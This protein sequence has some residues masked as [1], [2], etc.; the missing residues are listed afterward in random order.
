MERDCANYVPLEQLRME[1]SIARRTG[2]ETKLVELW[3]RLHYEF[4]SA[5]LNTLLSLESQ[6]NGL[7]L[8]TDTVEGVEELLKSIEKIHA[9][10]KSCRC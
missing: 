5:N 3:D 7:K 8:K 1:P 6:L 2:Y 10:F 4:G 9:D